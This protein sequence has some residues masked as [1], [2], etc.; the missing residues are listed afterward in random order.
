[1]YIRI[2]HCIFNL[3]KLSL[4]IS[5]KGII[6]RNSRHSV[7]N[8]TF[9]WNR[10]PLLCIA[11]LPLTLTMTVRR[12]SATP[13]FKYWAVNS[14][15]T[16]KRQLKC[17]TTELSLPS[18]HSLCYWKKQKAKT[19]LILSLVIIEKTKFK[20]SCSIQRKNPWGWGVFKVNH[21][22]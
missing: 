4:L 18:L 21:N 5:A 11:V 7:E 12:H 15:E 2:L 6:L 13:S 16:I 22:T 8:T 3:L 19:Y 10:S 17:Y 14:W 20:V 1:M 9:I